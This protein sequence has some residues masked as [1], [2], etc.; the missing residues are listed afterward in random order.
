MADYKDSYEYNFGGSQGANYSP[1]DEDEY[2]GIAQRSEDRLAPDDSYTK[3]EYNTYN[4]PFNR[5]YLNVDQYNY[6]ASRINS[7]KKVR[8]LTFEDHYKMYPYRSGSMIVPKDLYTIE[9]EVNLVNTN[10][11]NTAGGSWAQYMHIYPNGLY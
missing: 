1:G 11:I 5:A 3:N 2:N 10:P 4:A 9:W 8:P 6:L 7:I